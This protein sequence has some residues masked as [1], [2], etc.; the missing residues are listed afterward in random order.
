[1]LIGI[2][3]KAASGKDTIG[4]YLVKEHLFNKIS[5]ADPIKRLVKDVFVL[6]DFQVY[7]RIEREKNLEKWNGWSVR[8]LLQI[9]GT[10]LFREKIDEQIW[11]KSLYYRMEQL[12][13]NSVCVSN[14]CICD[15]RFP[16][17]VKYLKE[18]MGNDFV[19]IKV[20]RPGCDGNVGIKGHI[21]ESFDLNADIVIN[22]DGDKEKLYNNVRKIIVPIM[23]KK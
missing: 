10:E 6:D 15:I 18:K 14:Y 3:G 16:D 5:L 17:E 13:N 2:C 20:I 11:V 21:S 23:E 4:D 8:K 7:D 9:I 1:M 22:N 12:K 19:L